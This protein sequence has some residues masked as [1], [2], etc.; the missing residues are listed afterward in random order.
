[1]QVF[2]AIKAEKKGKKK[3]GNCCWPPVIFLCMPPR[4]FPGEI[5][6]N[7]EK[8]KKTEQ[9]VFLLLI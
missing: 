2:Q 6:Q 1:M 3:G 8:K 9:R 7:D 5:H 4:P